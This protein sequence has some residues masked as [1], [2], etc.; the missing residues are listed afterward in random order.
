MSPESKFAGRC[1][2]SCPLSRL[3]SEGGLLNAAFGMPAKSHSA[4]TVSEKAAMRNR[5]MTGERLSPC[6]TPTV[7]ESSAL[8]LPIRSITFRLS[9]KR[10][11]A[12]LNLGGAPYLSSTLMSSAWSAVS[13]ALI[14]S[15]KTTY[16]SRLCWWR[17]CRMVLS[18]KFA[19]AH[20]ALGTPPN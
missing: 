15:A 18:V 1:P 16:V 20:P 6:L 13:K 4:S 10:D 14:R 7:W 2:V 5:N 12:F 19:S 3:V 8:S 11:I 17:R 9:Y